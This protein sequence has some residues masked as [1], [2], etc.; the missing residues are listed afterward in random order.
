MKRLGI[1]LGLVSS[2]ILAATP[3]QALPDAQIIQKLQGVP[4]F[5]L[6]DSDGLLMTATSTTNKTPK[7][8]AFFSQSDARN[9]LQKLQRENPTLAKSLQVKT[10]ALSEMFKAKISTD[11]KQK[12]DIVFVPNQAQLSTALALAKQ[13]NPQLQRFDGVPMFVATATT[14]GKQKGYLTSRTADNKTIISF[15]FDRDQLQPLI[16]QFK[17]DHPKQANTV[18]VQVTSLESLLETMRSKND[19][20]YSQFVINPSQEGLDVLKSLAQ[21]GR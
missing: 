13:T 9:F 11:P 12:V 19:A 6:T 15:F 2:T 16:D 21:T 3:L 18:Q 7:G 10:V 5:A 1:A 8:G 20:I 4:V 14:N 17:K